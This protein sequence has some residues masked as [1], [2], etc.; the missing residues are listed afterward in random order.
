M[1]NRDRLGNKIRG[2]NNL[3]V[4]K[5]SVFRIKIICFHIKCKY[6]NTLANISAKKKFFSN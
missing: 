6:S 3:I 2:H 5:W 1:S 4:N